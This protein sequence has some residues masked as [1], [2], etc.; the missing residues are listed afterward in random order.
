M[1]FYV[2][3]YGFSSS[4]HCP[5]LRAGVI[6]TVYDLSYFAVHIPNTDTVTTDSENLTEKNNSVGNYRYATAICVAADSQCGSQGEGTV[7]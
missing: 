3:F 4:S 2:I 1:S 7:L 5:E 6:G